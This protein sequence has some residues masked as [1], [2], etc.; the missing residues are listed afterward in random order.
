[1]SKLLSANKRNDFIMIFLFFATGEYTAYE[2]ARHNC[3]LIL[4]G[5]N[6]SRLEAVRSKCLSYM[7]KRNEDNILIIPFDLTKF[8]LHKNALD[9]ALN[10]F[11]KV[12]DLVYK[13]T[14]LALWPAQMINTDLLFFSDRHSH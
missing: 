12:I 9:K 11:E 13:S 4:S 7:D 5:T 3:K 8:D 6:L 10:H 1:M 2:F 14:R